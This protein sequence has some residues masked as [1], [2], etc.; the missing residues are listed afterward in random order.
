MGIPGLFAWL[1]KK[2]SKL[3]LKYELLQHTD[4]LYID[5][6]CLFH[7]VC[8]K[9]QTDPECTE[10]KMIEGILKHLDDIIKLVNPTKLTFISVDGVPP[11]AKICQQ[12]KRRYK[13]VM[14]EI[15]R[16]QIKIKHGKQISKWTG[17]NITPGT[18]FMDKLD[19]AIV[20]HYKNN[21]QI[22]YSSYHNEGEGE[23]KI[24]DHIKNNLD[25]SQII[26]YGLDADLIILS[27]GLLIGKSTRIYLLRDN[28]G[29]RLSYLN[30]N[31]ILTKFNEE[32]NS[33][34]LINNQSDISYY[35]N[36][37]IFI[38]YFLGNDFLPRLP[39]L[40][41]RKNGGD[42]LLDIY[43]KC[44]N[45]NLKK[46]INN[47]CSINVDMLIDIFRSLS[48]S[49]LD[50]FKMN[51]YKHTK[52]NF[53]NDYEKDLWVYDNLFDNSIN[54]DIISILNIDDIKFKYYAHYLK[55]YEHQEET[56]NELCKKY[57]DGLIWILEYYIKG[58]KN[59]EWYYP[60][61][62]APF[63]SDLYKFLI[64]N[65]NYIKYKK[66]KA[67]KP[68]DIETQLLLVIPPQYKTILEM[69]NIKTEKIFNSLKTVEQYPISF[70]LDTFDND[71][72]WQCSPN[73]SLFNPIKLYKKNIK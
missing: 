42:L 70:T 51:N 8:N 7:P 37:I 23:H 58:C 33:F 69:K 21:N 49:E 71:Q 38:S 50:Y 45:N 25:N 16:N 26:I 10:E 62:H 35:L 36:D 43:I 22:V 55:T 41:V 15:A 46:L 24:M 14:D 2:Y 19:N 47:D 31:E 27:L 6:N 48:N 39:T 66:Y 1:I 54:K 72:Y 53:N 65:K 67:T 3:L 20:N 4:I 29:E 64:N 57:I 40:N 32:I 13:T 56:I 60:Y 61:D 52:Y 9:L 11:M 30:I 44:Y 73:L 18:L 59:W 5:A 34:T 28:I 17:I 63:P 12:R 68:I